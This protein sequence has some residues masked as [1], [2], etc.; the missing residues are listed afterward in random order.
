MLDHILWRLFGDPALAQEE[1][2]KAGDI[3]RRGESSCDWGSPLSRGR[4][5]RQGECI[6]VDP[7][8]KPLCPLTTVQHQ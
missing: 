7:T 8:L 4:G 5:S 1:A 6:G 3:R 2:E